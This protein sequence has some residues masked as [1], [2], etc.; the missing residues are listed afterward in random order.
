MRIGVIGGG[1]TLAAVGIGYDEVPCETPFGPTAAPMRCGRYGSHA[2]FSM[3][4]HGGGHKVG[5]HQVNY[6]AN[7]WAFHQQKVDLL[8]GASICGSLDPD[9]ELG[10]LAIYD[11]I[12]D[13]TRARVSTF[14]DQ[15]TEVRNV[16]VC[17]PVCGG[18]SRAWV[19]D[20]LRSGGLPF[21]DGG[22][23]VVIEGPRFSTRAESR[24]FSLLGGQF[25]T[26]SAAPEAFL[27]R[28]LGLCYVPISLVT[29][30]DTAGADRVTVER[31]GNSVEQFRDRIPGAMAALLADIDAFRPRP[32]AGCIGAATPVPVDRLNLSGKRDRA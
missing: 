31:I 19:I 27:A 22:T 5:A 25:I 32:C 4:R 1:D 16:D 24:M 21:T 29:D 23:M 11:Q 18:S 30:H 13:F 3:L 15:G 17:E 12:I 14:F 6:R 20:R 26:M 9:V 7:V 2:I 10:T 28:E 8:L